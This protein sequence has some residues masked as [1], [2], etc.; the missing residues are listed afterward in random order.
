MRYSWCQTP[1][2]RNQTTV[3]VYAPKAYVVYPQK[4]PTMAD[5]PRWEVLK[6]IRVRVYR[7]YAMSLNNERSRFQ[8]TSSLGT[9]IP[10]FFQRPSSP[11]RQQSIFAFASP[12]RATKI[13]IGNYKKNTT[14]G[15]N[16]CV[17]LK[18]LHSLGCFDAQKIESVTE[19][20]RSHMH[21]GKFVSLVGR[22]I[23]DDGVC[24]K[25]VELAGEL[26]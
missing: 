21:K 24:V 7:T 23:E 19:D 16:W 12:Q 9:L 25:C 4:E 18:T 17:L 8:E 6:P 5:P 1:L 15:A 11:Q 14:P 2:G 26:D 22:P 3:Q 20:S 10:W 13:I